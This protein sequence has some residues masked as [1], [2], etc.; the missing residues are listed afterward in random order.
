MYASAQYAINQG[1][2]RFSKS[3]WVLCILTKI[4]YLPI[5]GFRHHSS[6]VA[7]LNEFNRKMGNDS[8]LLGYD[9]LCLFN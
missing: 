6:G 9:L 5:H 8:F 7:A 2:Q 4:G 1:R 3:K